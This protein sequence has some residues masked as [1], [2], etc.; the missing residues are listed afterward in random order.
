ME[1]NVYILR[2]YGPFCNV[3]EVRDWETENNCPCNL[4]LISGMKKYAKTS[5]HYYIGKAERNFISDRFLDKGHHINDFS[6]VQEIWV[7][8]IANKRASH[9]DVMLIENML[10]SYVAGEIGEDK[11]LNKIN[12]CLPSINVYILAEWINP[13]TQTAWGKLSRT[14]P[15]SIIPDVIVNKT[16]DDTFN[17]NLY[18]SKKLKKQ[19]KK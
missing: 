19:Q 13:I 17:Y 1:K 16:Y 4:Y 7:G 8:T 15:G 2:W 18:V 14:S 12:F 11:M 9:G 6:R 10:T 3:D 5:I